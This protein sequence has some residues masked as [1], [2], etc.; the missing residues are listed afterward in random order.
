MSIFGGMG[1]SKTSGNGGGRGSFFTP[2]TYRV[3]LLRH[4]IKESLRKSGEPAVIIECKVDA[5]LQPGTT[6]DGQPTEQNQPGTKAVQ[7]CCLDRKRDGTFTDKGKMG[8]ERLKGHLHQA[9]G[10]EALGITEDMV[11][12][13]MAEALFI[14]T[15]EEPG[16]EEALAGTV[17]LVECVQT[18][19]DKANRAFDNVYWRYDAKTNEANA[20]QAEG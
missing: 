15:K 11:D 5:I 1:K 4:V 20:E 18:W 16:S 6:H 14:G 12:E 17:M 7:F 19:S 2:G 3:T 9:L 13:D 8:M 10:G